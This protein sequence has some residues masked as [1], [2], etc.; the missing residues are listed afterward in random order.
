MKNSKCLLLA[1]LT[2]LISSISYSATPDT[3]SII[4]NIYNYEFFKARERLSK[5]S[6]NDFLVRET[7][8]LEIKWWMS[9]ERGNQNQF[10][11]FLTTL[12]QM[13]SAEMN[14]LSE[15]IFLT[16]RMRYY[17]SNNRLFKIPY[18]FLKIQNKISKVDIAQISKSGNENMELFLLY[19]SFLALIQKSYLT[20]IIIPDHAG[21]EQLIENIERIAHNGSPSNR[22]L[23]TYFLMK[24]YL[25]IGKDRPKALDY[26]TVL[27]K[28]YPNN[29]IFTQLLT[30]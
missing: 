17:A 24:Y 30:N 16:Y 26:L 19:K 5:L 27:H 1:I 23:G 8:D 2:F 18:M 15:I 6:G 13:E 21:E 12:N 22:T 11:D 9:L 14:Q 20:D 7:L 4:D 25:E 28:Q 3:T 10:S 29:L